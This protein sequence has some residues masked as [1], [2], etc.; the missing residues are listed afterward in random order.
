MDAYIL[1]SFT[2]F[3]ALNLKQ[4]QKNGKAVANVL[5]RGYCSL[6]SPALYE[7]GSSFTFCFSV[8]LLDSRSVQGEL[9]WVANPTEGGV[10]APR[11]DVVPG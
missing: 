11:W 1:R 4:K 7:E 9:G 3:T 8:T 5:I 2:H 6:Q 10:S